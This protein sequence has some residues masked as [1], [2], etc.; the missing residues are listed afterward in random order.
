MD[1]GGIGFADLMKLA[2]SSAGQQLLRYVQ[3]KDS[4]QLREAMEYAQQGDVTK[5]KDI[6]SRILASPQADALIQQIRSEL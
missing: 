1:L 2:N 4:E 5:A 3:E 6:I